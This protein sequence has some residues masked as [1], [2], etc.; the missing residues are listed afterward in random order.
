MKFPRTKKSDESTQDG[1][2]SPVSDAES[3][4]THRTHLP[5]KE[6][7]PGASESTAADKDTDDYDFLTELFDHQKPAVVVSKKP[8]KKT[9]VTD[10]LKGKPKKTAAEKQPP[11]NKTLRLCLILGIILA[12]LIAAFAGFFTFTQVTGESS[13]IVDQIKL[14]FDPNAGMARTEHPEETAAPEPTQVPEKKDGLTSLL[15]D[16][17]SLKSIAAVDPSKTITIDTENTFN[18]KNMLGETKLLFDTM[19]SMTSTGKLSVQVDPSAEALQDGEVETDFTAAQ[20]WLFDGSMLESAGISSSENAGTSSQLRDAVV[21]FSLF[22]KDESGNT[23]YVD[24]VAVRRDTAENKTEEGSPAEQIKEHTSGRVYEKGE[25][26]LVISLDPSAPLLTKRTGITAALSIP[27]GD[28]FYAGKQTS[29]IP[30][31]IYASEQDWETVQTAGISSGAW[32]VSEFRITV[33]PAKVPVYYQNKQYT[34]IVIE[35]PW[36][37]SWKVSGTGTDPYTGAELILNQYDEAGNVIKT[38]GFGWKGKY[39]ADTEQ[40]TAEFQPG[41]YELGVF[42]RGTGIT[43]DFQQLSKEMPFYNNLSVRGK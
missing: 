3:L 23:V 7:I 27:E 38:Y 18:T 13:E 19:Q 20:N 30:G 39:S 9:T 33:N 37:I 6:T 26:I 8:V 12:V 42:L 31:G 36:R 17:F 28:Y 21:Y 16:A 2:E 29:D 24:T 34:T 35:E 1:T 43:L 10:L 22:K 25:Y 14:F 15:S 32:V 41:E 40:I 5:E 11:K 4:L